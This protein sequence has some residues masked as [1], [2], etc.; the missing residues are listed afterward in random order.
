MEGTVAATNC[1]V[2]QPSA[3]PLSG[4]GPLGMPQPGVTRVCVAG[5]LVVRILVVGACRMAGT[6][7]CGSAINRDLVFGVVCLHCCCTGGCTTCEQHAA[8]GR[9]A[10]SKA[11]YK[12]ALVGTDTPHPVWGTSGAAPS[13]LA[14]W[15]QSLHQR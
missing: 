6:P 2:A 15:Q 1:Q 12:P 7:P 9:G 14:S 3:G 5:V 10:V 4:S 11:L 13:A 8:L